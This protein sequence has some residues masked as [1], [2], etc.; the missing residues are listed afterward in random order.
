MSLNLADENWLTKTQFKTEFGLG[1]SSYQTRIKKMTAGDSD[2]KHGYAKVS[3]KEVYINKE[4]Y[5][6]WR[7]SEAEK[8]SSGLITRKEGIKNEQ[9]KI[10][11]S[12]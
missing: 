1:E 6:A 5:N 10:L 3:N 4:V 11:C 8:K 2:F 7:S 9:N 12:A